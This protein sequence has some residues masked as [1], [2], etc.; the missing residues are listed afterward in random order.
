MAALWEQRS[1]LTD[2]IVDLYHK[3][4][5]GEKDKDKRHMMLTGLLCAYAHKLPLKKLKEWKDMLEKKSGRG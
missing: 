2:D 5:D 1:Q 4:Y 3:V